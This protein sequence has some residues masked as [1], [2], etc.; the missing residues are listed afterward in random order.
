[1]GFYDHFQRDITFANLPFKYSYISLK[2]SYKTSVKTLSII[3]LRPYEHLKLYI[4]LCIFHVLRTF[5]I[6]QTIHSFPIKFKSL[7]SKFRKRFFIAVK[8]RQFQ[9]FSL[10]CSLI[11]NV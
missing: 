9:V 1:M 2:Q 7:P 6:Y 4:I 5:Y 10:M 3:L 8:V 11:V